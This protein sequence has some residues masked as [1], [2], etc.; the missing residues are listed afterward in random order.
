ML[1]IST[2][3][4]PTIYRNLYE[5]TAP[6]TLP[7]IHRHHIGQTTVTTP[8]YVITRQTEGMDIFF[9]NSGPVL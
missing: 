1:A 3:H 4:K 8:C 9:F 7:L 2:N 5:N 6:D